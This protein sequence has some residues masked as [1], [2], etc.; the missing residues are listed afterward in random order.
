MISRTGRKEARA[1]C[2]LLRHTCG[3]GV[4]KCPAPFFLCT[5]G[6]VTNMAFQ[7]HEGPNNYRKTSPLKRHFIEVSFFQTLL[8]YNS[9]GW[10]YMYLRWLHEIEC[11][12]QFTEWGH[13]VTWKV[14]HRKQEALTG[15]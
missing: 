12:E 15:D 4:A 10:C 9:V 13:F 7:M 3:G 11:V 2:P 14:Y 1:T 5:A 8:I 6:H